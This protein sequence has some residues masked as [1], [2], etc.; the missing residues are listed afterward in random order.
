MKP[1]DLSENAPWKKR[2][3]V[4]QAVWAT[5]AAGNPARGLVC[6]N[7]TGKLQLYSWETASGALTQLTDR[8]KGQ[9]VGVIDATGE[10]IYYLQDQAGNEQGHFVRVPFAGG[11]P[12]DITPSLALYSSW[13]IS[14][15]AAGSHLGFVASGREGFKLM[16]LEQAADGALGEPRCIWTSKALSTGPW[17]NHDGSVALV[18][19][20]E[21]SGR[22]AYALLALDTRSGAILNE[23]E[24]A[25]ASVSCGGLAPAAVGPLAAVTCN[26]SGHHRPFLWNWQTG[27]RTPI[28]SEEF[29]GELQCLRFNQAGDALLLREAYRAQHRLYRYDLSDG[30]VRRLAIPE[31]SLGFMGGGAFFMP[32]GEI[33]LNWQ[34]ATTPAGVIAIDDQTGAFKRTV[35]APGEV[36][37]SQAWRSVDMES[38]GGALIQAWVATP[39]GTGPWPLILH[40]HG[41]P[42]SVMTNAFHAE[43]QAWLDHGFAFMS[44]NY[45][46]SITFG[47]AYEEAIWGNLGDWEIDDMAAARAWA[48][49]NGIAQ[50]DAVLL[51]GGSYGGYLTLQALGRRPELWAG[52]MADVAIADWRLMY[53]DQAETL[54]GYQRA[55]FGG[56]P[57]TAGAA[58]D[59]S[60][61]ITYAAQ[62]AAPLLVLQGRNDSRCPARQMEQF[63]AKL[64]DLGKTIELQWFDAGHGSYEVAERIDF[65]AR[66]M[67]FAYRI[68][69]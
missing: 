53:E 52:G 56:G 31:G 8:P 1:L 32:E 67:A 20:T 10:F 49:A 9:Q 27:T 57:E 46:G 12:Q 68:L 24:E 13:Q 47:K 22:N 44:V 38:T 54:R 29:A 66:R 17:L 36:P 19:T 23:W 16:V 41:G 42:T 18:M 33:W 7:R 61:P 62:Y 26:V 5:V 50:P 58:Y 40:T 14:T 11:E 55:L 34:S 15:S 48:V 30:R 64:K 51:I 59:K 69:G 39:A 2:Y 43:A 4:P 3:T 6:H 65:Q 21:R 60:S 45:R 25:A 28:E 35:L 63:E 37:A